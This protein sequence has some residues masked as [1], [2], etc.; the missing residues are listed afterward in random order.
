[1][2]A[3]PLTFT[4]KNTPMTA[5]KS[6]LPMHNDE[7]EFAQRFSASRSWN[8]DCLERVV[9]VAD[10]EAP[11]GWLLVDPRVMKMEAQAL[12]G[13]KATSASGDI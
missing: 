4:S 7:D 9:A 6:A 11:G 1:M 3:V 2:I 5:L 10:D 8:G 13:T 12:P